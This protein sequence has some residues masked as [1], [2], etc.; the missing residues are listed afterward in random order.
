MPPVHD[1]NILSYAAL[2]LFAPVAMIVLAS[3]RPEVGVAVVLVGATLLLP[4]LVAFDP[5]LL[6]PFDKTTI[7]C[8]C[9]LAGLLLFRRGRLAAA[10]PG[11]RVDLFLVLLMIGAIGTVTTNA[12]AFRVG[13]VA[14][15]ALA[16]WDVLSMVVRDLLAIAVPFYLGRAV[17]RDARDARTLLLVLVAGAV[18]YAPLIFV[19]LV[20]SPQLHRW[21][22]GFHQHE[23]VQTMRGG[24]YRPMV[25][26]SHGLAVA[27][28][29]AIACVAATAF[30]RERIRI[31]P[32][33]SRLVAAGLLVVL[34]SCKSSAAAV[35]IA[36]LVP[37]AW[38]AAPRAQALIV[39]VAACVTLAYPL[40][41]AT[42]AFPIDAVVTA[43]KTISEQR[44]ASVAFRFQNERLLLDRAAE[45][46]WF[47]WGG[48][49]RGL[50]FDEDSGKQVAIPDG[51]WI[52]Q[53]GTRGVVG[54]VGVFG[55]LSWPLLAFPRSLARVRGKRDRV[56]LC[57]LALVVAVSLVD[58]LPNGLYTC[59][60]FYL[61]GALYGASR[62]R[63]G[64]L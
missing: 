4:E 56:V 46:P 52:V 6:P 59:L 24:G 21:V 43:S 60:P 23:F 57:G 35:Y 36:V 48:F 62:A 3:T 13:P 63:A 16:P 44:A 10:P 33:S 40:L 5:P 45:R 39:A 17:H 31:A 51:H 50:V 20:M 7:A 54:F 53:L 8:T 30:A 27:L 11:R 9:A 38:F 26:M 37:L 41:R 22:Y 64:D 28:F 15:G 14:I 61:A 18:A 12:D 34:L 47:G 32:L 25:F 42:E 29:V 58:L 19:E 1:A 49:Q 55:L 2:L